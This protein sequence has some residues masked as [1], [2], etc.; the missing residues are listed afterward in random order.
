MESTAAQITHSK[1]NWTGFLTTA[2]RLYKYPYPE[3][4]MIYAQRPNA[5]ACAS[6]ELWNK[7][8]GR[9]VHRH[10]QGIALIDA[11]GDTP[12]L[13]Y[14][15]DVSDTGGR[16]Q[17][18]RPL[19]WE[20]RSEHEDI[21]SSVLEREYGVS[22]RDG[23]AD[24]IR[25][26]AAQLADQHW[27]DNRRDI[28]YNIDGSYAAEY[29]EFNQEAAFVQAT[30]ISITYA[31]LSRCGFDPDE[32]IDNVEYLNVFDFN[33]PN[34]V[35]ALGTA[36]SAGTEQLLRQIERTVKQYEQE[37]ERSADHERDQLQAERGLSDSRPDHDSAA[38]GGDRQ[39]REDAET[40]S[41]GASA[42]VLQFPAAVREAVPA[43]VGDRADG[44]RAAANDDAAAYGIG[45]RD[46]SVESV[47][48]DEVGTPDKRDSEPGGRDRDAG[49]DLQLISEAEQ[50]S[51][52]EAEAG[53]ASASFVSQQDI[54]DV[55]FRGSGFQSGK[56]RIYEF[57]KSQN[58]DTK[59]AV[60]FLKKEFGIGGGSY[61]YRN[62][63][64]G[65]ADHD[66]KGLSFS[67]GDSKEKLV[68]SWTKVH[69][70]IGEHIT[71]E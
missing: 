66:S 65:M 1:Q 70:R 7:R 24:Q 14:V 46:G 8:M 48:S 28:L 34:A 40:V 55:L 62:E 71:Y 60:A 42:N 5:T 2:A 59:A 22:G 17:S 57:N 49:A 27:Q 23:L 9:F 11:T 36:V 37:K 51:L 63:M 53:N 64:R 61:T 26:V 16:E 58:P 13:K 43:P 35:T 4:L 56:F 15:F 67:A 3:Q 50:I 31:A 68:L 12:R 19:L 21:V 69:R 30:A 47:R 41:D 44:D 38:N 10:S 20:M 29:D 54:D 33:T 52:I 18:H 6:Y 32:S 45:G 25:A 39:V